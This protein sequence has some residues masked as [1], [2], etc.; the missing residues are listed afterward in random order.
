MVKWFIGEYQELT[1]RVCEVVAVEEHEHAGKGLQLSGGFFQIDAR[2]VQGHDQLLAF[3]GGAFTRTA[4]KGG[5]GQVGVR[6]QNTKRNVEASCFCDQ[7][8]PQSD[9]VIVEAGVWV[10]TNSQR[11]VGHGCPWGDW[12][13]V[14]EV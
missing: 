14:W 4:I 6:P 10:D 11:C 3:V 8:C 9:E 12:G 1:T 13:M 5:K 2:R 7:V